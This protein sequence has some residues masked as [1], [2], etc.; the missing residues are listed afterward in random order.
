[1]KNKTFFKSVVCAVR[2]FAYALKTEKNYAYY[3]AVTLVFL[4]VNILVRVDFYC[5]IFQITATFGVFS[6]ECTNTAIEHICNKITTDKD[7]K[8]K[9]IKDIAA[10][11]VL[12][13]GAV[14]FTAEFIFI[15]RAVLC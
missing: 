5:Y 12:C 7:P 1:M 15:G 2:G 14:F 9:L 10:G 6:S 13:W 8:I 4:L 11:S 3:L